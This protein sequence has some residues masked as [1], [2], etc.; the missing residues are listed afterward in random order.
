MPGRLRRVRR[1]LFVGAGLIF[2]VIMVV[3]VVT[4][5]GVHYTD[6]VAFCGQFCHQVMEPQYTA[7]QNSP[8]SRV[9]CVRC[10]LG[11]DSQ[12]SV[13]AKLSG[14]R[15]IFATAFNTYPRP[16]PSPITSLR[17]T[18]QTCEE[19]HRPEMFHGD[20]LL[21]KEKFQADEENTAVRTVLLLKVGS[22]GYHGREAHGIHWHVSPLNSVSYRAADP[23]RE[24]ITEVRLR[25]ANGSEKI[26]TDRKS[27]GT[28]ISGET[29]EMD[30]IDCHNRPSHIFLT[31]DE[32]LNRKLLIGAIP[33]SLPYVK[34]AGLAAL[35]GNY[36]STAAARSGITEQMRQWYQQPE[37]GFSGVREADLRL[38]I[39]GIFQAWQE[40]V[41]PAMGVT[42]DTYRDFIG[43]R[44]DSGC[45]RCH[46]NRLRTNNGETIPNACDTCHIILAEAEPT[47][48][49]LKILRGGDH[50]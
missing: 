37:P 24:K 19:C 21:I 27:G 29:R 47:P 42:W 30:C 45:F 18:R 32:A 38:A 48:D 44:D 36:D 10:H 33:T 35:N 11:S 40:N 39:D 15:Q 13:G 22:G 7:Y 3:A 17:P 20:R 9:S 16:I 14:V 50:Q 6:S 26:F 4:Y 8:H 43:H 5:S 12:W 28:G 41:F 2:A 1:L 34:K 31:P 49:V 25:R 23:Q 46:N